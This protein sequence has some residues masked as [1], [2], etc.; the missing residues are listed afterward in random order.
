MNIRWRTG[1]CMP[2]VL[3]QFTSKERHEAKVKWEY[4]QHIDS[5]VVWKIENYVA[6]CTIEE[7]E[8]IYAAVSF[9]YRLGWATK[10]IDSRSITLNDDEEVS[11]K[12]GFNRLSSVLPFDLLPVV[13]FLKRTQLS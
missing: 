8:G 7:G 12:R 2:R 3:D 9:A 11:N 6:L 10:L 1:E 5:R 4:A 13:V